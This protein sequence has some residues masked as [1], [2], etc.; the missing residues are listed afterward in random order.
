MKTSLHVLLPLAVVLG[1]LVLGAEE[2]SAQAGGGP[3]IHRL[4]DAERKDLGQ[5]MGRHDWRAHVRNIGPCPIKVVWFDKQ[6][7]GGKW[8]HRVLQP[9]QTWTR[10]IQFGEILEVHDVPDHHASRFASNITEIR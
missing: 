10:R 7:D 4:E 1:S 8:K 6:A 2:A 5:N 3:Q 9:G